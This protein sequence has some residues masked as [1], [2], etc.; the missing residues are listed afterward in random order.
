[1]F[2]VPN[3]I[4]D[5]GI[6]GI[7]IMCSAKMGLPLGYFT[8]FLNLPFIFLALK[9]FGAMFVFYT[10]WSVSMLSCAVTIFE[11]INRNVSDP[12]LA[13]VFGGVLLG[14]G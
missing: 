2:L 6:V 9:R 10:F 12:M 11:N 4:I 1:M 3:N 7:S 5:G 14:C 8:F 13:C